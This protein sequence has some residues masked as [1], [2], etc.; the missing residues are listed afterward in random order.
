MAT[1]ELQANDELT[2]TE[3]EAAYDA[4]TPPEMVTVALGVVPDT[5]PPLNVSV[6]TPVTVEPPTTVKLP[7][8]PPPPFIAKEAVKA[9]EEVIAKDEV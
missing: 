3:D 8:P 6:V 5:V 9:Y 2:A 4:L 7:P 1:D